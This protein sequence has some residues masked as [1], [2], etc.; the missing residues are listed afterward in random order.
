MF[1]SYKYEL[2]GR[3]LTTLEFGK[4]AEQASGS[5]FVRY[6]DTVL[7]TATPTQRPG[8]DFSLSVDFE[9]KLYRRRQDSRRLDPP[10]RPSG[11]KSHPDQPP[12]RPAASPAVPRECATTCPSWRPSCRWI[13]T[14]P[15]NPRDDRLVR[16]AFNQLHSLRRP[17]RRGQRRLYRWRLRHQPTTTSAP[18]PFAP[19]RRRHQG[20]RHD[21][22]G[23]RE[24]GLRRGHAGRHTV[25]PRGDQKLVA[26]QEQIVSGC[27][28]AQARIPADPARR[29]REGRRARIRDG[30]GQS[31]L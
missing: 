24:G 14:T 11:R 17:H 16:R 28:P 5:V 29:R 19:D 6:G 3:T 27:R 7:V 20:C 4:Y 10:R 21:G 1:K 23:Q 26:F 9:E 30:A 12:D 8:I 22:R 31:R 25:R 13:P 15:R 2:G 18:R